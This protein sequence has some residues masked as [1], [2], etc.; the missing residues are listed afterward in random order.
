MWVGKG[1]YIATTHPL[2]AF[3]VPPNDLY[4]EFDHHSK[5]TCVTINTKGGSQDQYG[6]G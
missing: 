3:K 5:G 2:M 6:C 4:R 1:R